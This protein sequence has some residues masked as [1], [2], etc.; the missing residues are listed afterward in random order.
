MKNSVDKR[1]Q[2]AVAKRILT[3][4]GLGAVIAAIAWFGWVKWFALAIALAMVGEVIGAKI[5]AKKHWPCFANL[6]FILYSLL[7]ILSAFAVGAKPGIMLLLLLIIAAADTGA[8]FFGCRIKSSKMWEAVSAGKSWA[9]QIAG[10]ICGTATSILYGMIGTDIFLPQLMWIGFSVSLLSQ[11][12][13]LAES[14]IKRNFGIKD[15][16]AYLPGHGGL[17]D[18][19]DGWIFVLPLVWAATA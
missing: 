7:F 11:Y 16:G 8:W 12:G 6:F 4:L 14:A 18:R 17:S 3:A 9:G 13:D 19:F 15:M 10:I 1:R 5:R 2:G